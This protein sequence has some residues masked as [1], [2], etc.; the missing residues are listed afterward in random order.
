MVDIVQEAFGT[1]PNIKHLKS[2]RSDCIQ[3]FYGCGKFGKGHK[4]QIQLPLSWVAN[5]QRLIEDFSLTIF[6]E[7]SVQENFDLIIPLL[8]VCRKVYPL[9]SRPIV[10]P[11]KMHR[12]VL[13]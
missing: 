3:T 7:F 11:D 5:F 9:K 4:V 13:K 6:I 1:S 12:R 10:E 2:F 8:G